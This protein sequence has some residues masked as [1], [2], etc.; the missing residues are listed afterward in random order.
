MDF[1]I[2][3]FLKGVKSG[4]PIAL[5][6]ASYGVVF[7]VLSRQAGLDADHAL[8]MSAFVFAGASQF[9]ALD[10][11]LT[12]LPVVTIIITTF[13]VNMRHIL[14][15]AVL[16]EKFKS[17]TFPQKYA[18]LFFLVDENW[19]YSLNAWKKG[20]NNA[21]LLLGTGFIIFLSWFAST[22]VGS[23]LGAGHIDPV[24]W[25]IDFAFT[26]IFIFLAIGLWQDKRDL[27]PWAVAAGVAVLCSHFLPGKWYILCGSISGSITGVLIHDK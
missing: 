9:V 27:V 16:T 23:I 18:S 4:F 8:L 13:V 1:T 5:G 10:M 26:A 2:N 11:W 6:V 19:A 21:A 20:D 24:K 22:A 3:G 25:G 14:M 17:L 7:G 12:P 15:G